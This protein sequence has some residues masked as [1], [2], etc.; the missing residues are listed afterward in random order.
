MLPQFPA[1]LAIYTY[2]GKGLSG[3]FPKSKKT[4]FINDVAPQY[5]PIREYYV[6]EYH[7]SSQIDWSA[8]D[9]RAL[10][11]WHPNIVTN[12]D[13]QA[14]TIFF[15]SDLTGKMVIICEGITF[16]GKIGYSEVIYEVDAP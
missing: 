2:S 16:E 8:P 4:N 14:K 11:D 10:L 3:A 6:R 1:I 9:R 15:N 12:K 5:S 13:G 7:D